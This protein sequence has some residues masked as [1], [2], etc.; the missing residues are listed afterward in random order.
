MEGFKSGV[1][2]TLLVAVL[3]CEKK[4]PIREARVEAGG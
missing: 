3:L 2:N 4:K 1:K